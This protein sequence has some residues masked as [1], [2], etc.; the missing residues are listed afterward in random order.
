[1]DVFTPYIY[2][3]VREYGNMLS[4]TG[5]L[6]PGITVAQADAEASRLIPTL[7]FSVKRGL[8]G[9][10]YT[11]QVRDLK[12]Y[13]AG[14]L[15]RSLIVLWC[16]VGLILL[17]V[18]VN[19]SNLLLARAAARSR[20]FAMRSALGAG[21]GRI[22]RQL[23]TESLALSTVGA[24]LGLLLAYAGVFYLAHQNS[25][26][27]PLLTS[28][29]IDI[30]ALAW[31]VFI[32]I[33]AALLFGIV[34]GLRISSSNLQEALKDSGH[35]TSAG[36][37]HDRVRSAL[38]VSEIAFACVLLI[39]AG[40][41]LRSFL[42]VLDVDLGFNPSQA[43]AIQLSHDDHGHA[44]ERG[45]YDR[46]VLRQIEAIPGVQSA[47]I[48]DSLPMSRN[49]AWG[50]SMIADSKND[51]DY[52]DAVVYLIT[53]G[54]LHTAGMRL[55]KGRDLTWNDNSKDEAVVIINQTLARTLFGDQDPI[56]RL[57]PSL[58]ARVIGVIEDVHE[59][60]AEAGAS[61]QMYLA[62]NASQWDSEDQKLV[63][64]STIPAQTLQPT[65]FA[66]LHQIN[67]GQPAAEL[68]PIQLL[69]DHS[70]SPRRFFVYLVSGFA[71]LGLLLASLGIYGV[72]AYSVTQ[73]TQ[74]IGIRMALGATRANV[75][76]GVVRQTLRLTAI[77]IAVGAV[78]SL[79]VSSLIAS[80]LFNTRPNDPPTFA[81]IAVLLAI[82][83]IVA[84]Y[85]P[86]RHA[87]RIDPMVALRNA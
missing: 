79:A 70:S 16:A 7:D 80:L 40:L 47:G 6:R 72:I 29:H 77:G 9:K 28:I 55:V 63:I 13:I 1:M 68:K 71:A 50:V 34:P 2:D 66:I 43:S 69:V 41:L 24:V 52:Q 27:L 58:K 39:G 23:L 81:C 26:A 56:D 35:G 65:V 42:R 48:T 44:A 76:L 61:S 86:A 18:C 62:A 20:E 38:V 73:R 3:T 67:P 30:S 5:R 32:A 11:A 49:R 19:L 46:E 84:G 60:S 59:T 36:R 64:R 45:V 21:R 54:Y 8:S 57:I 78:A 12:D 31:T 4:L 25:I 37:K 82:V 85:L 87:S 14:S 17:I 51:A 83:A 75:Q 15:R 22:I 74:E 53:P 10:S 33:I